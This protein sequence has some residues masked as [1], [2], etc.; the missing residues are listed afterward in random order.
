MGFLDDEKERRQ[1]AD[2]DGDED[3]EF[4]EAVV[5]AENILGSEPVQ[6]AE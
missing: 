4:F 2:A 5:E 1:W 6:Q 3:E